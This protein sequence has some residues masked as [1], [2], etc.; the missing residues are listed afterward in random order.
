VF[1]Q[2]NGLA[3]SRRGEENNSSWARREFF[4]I[5]VAEELFVKAVGIGIGFWIVSGVETP[6]TYVDEGA[7]PRGPI[8]VSQLA[9]NVG[10]GQSIFGSI[11]E[12]GIGCKVTGPLVEGSPLGD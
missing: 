9:L 10:C 7:Q 11:L 3:Q 12:C 1:F 8:Q 4:L 5:V 2:V 6:K